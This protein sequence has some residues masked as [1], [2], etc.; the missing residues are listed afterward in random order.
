M[1]GAETNA[2]RLSLM[3]Q[4]TKTLPASSSPSSPSSFLPFDCL[5]DE[6]TQRGYGGSS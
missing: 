1:Y 2:V 5:S 6:Q 3:Q 4:M